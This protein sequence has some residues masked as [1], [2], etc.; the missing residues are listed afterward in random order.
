MRS[1]GGIY[2]VKKVLLGDQVVAREEQ[3][4]D[5]I[6]EERNLVVK[7]AWEVWA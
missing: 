2:S 4:W 1:P 7:P 3:K 6:H 5:G